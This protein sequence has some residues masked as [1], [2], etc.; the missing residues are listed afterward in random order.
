MAETLPRLN[1]ALDG[2]Y[3]IERIIGQG[4][5]ATVYLAHDDK[6]DRPVA[7]KILR[8]DLAAVM[9]AERFLS[10]IKTTANLQHPHILPLHDSGNADGFLFYVMPFVEGESLRALLDREKQLGIDEALRIAKQVGSALDYAHRHGVIHRDIKPENVLMHDG[11]PLVADFGIA[12]AVTAAGAGRLTETGLSLGTPYYMS[13]EQATADRTPGP[14]SDVYSLGCMLYEM[15]VG[16]PPHTGSSAQAV[17][18]KILTERP[19]SVTE[20]RET[21]PPHVGAAVAKALERLPADRFETAGALIKALDDSGFTHTAVA[22]TATAAAQPAPTKPTKR[23]QSALPWG[24]AAVATGVALWALGSEPP[25][26]LVTR[27]NLT[28][29]EGQ[30]FSERGVPANLN[31][32]AL[33]PDGSQLVYLGPPSPG[34]APGARAQLWRRRLDELSATPIAGTENVVQPNFSRTGESLSFSSIGAAAG[35]LGVIPAEG[36]TPVWVAGGTS[37]NAWGDDGAIYFR[38]EGSI[39]RWIPGEAEAAAV[40]PIDRNAAVFDVLPGSNAVLLSDP[41]SMFVVD[42]AS[43]ELRDLGD[44][45]RP[46]YLSS[47]HIV[48][49]RVDDNALLVQPFDLKSLATKGPAVSTSA[50]VQSGGRI[51]GEYTLSAEGSLVYAMGGA[52]AGE[53]LIWVDRNG[54]REVIEW[55]EPAPYDGIALSPSGDRVAAGWGGGASAQGG[56]D[57]W[58]FDLVER[59]R[60][61]LTRDGSSARPQWHPSG[62]RISFNRSDSTGNAVWSVAT[63]GSGQLERIVELP[64]SGPAD[65][66]WSSEGRE[67]LLRQQ[68][69]SMRSLFRFVPGEHDEAQPWLDRAFNERNPAPSPDGNWL[70]YTSDQSGRDEVYAQPYPDGGAVTPV[71]I[72]GG[73]SALWSRDGSEVFFLGL[74]GYMWSASV[75]FDATRFMVDSRERLFEVGGLANELQR[76]MH[77]VAQD[78]RFLF[79]TQ[80]EVQAQSQLVLVRNWVQEVTGRSPR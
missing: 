61:P 40:A 50:V 54:L 4:G 62:D 32:T 78:G 6:H 36:G 29:P 39:M 3:R 73:Y 72:E 59:A 13:P 75:T 68:G 38:V 74:D 45:T 79:T 21:V 15:L 65:A 53:Q 58:T 52:G 70:L 10:E 34:A 55:I 23:W 35:S 66:W 28:T 42:L 48:Y 26:G 47:G 41:S 30:E 31:N 1:A 24:I 64:P 56:T 5:M 80:G 16:D 9:G 7:L 51:G 17:L 46:K 11:Q 20:L 63:D 71:S 14:Q 76:R 27:V 18:A 49:M 2:R 60:L 19:R 8:P 33:S 12:L 57:I 67:L 43:G 44:G 69:V 77:D 25:A 22:R 37:Y